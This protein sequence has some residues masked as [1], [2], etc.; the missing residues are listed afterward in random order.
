MPR[1]LPSRFGLRRARTERVGRGGQTVYVVLLIIA[2]VAVIVAVTFPAL[3]F[4]V[5]YQ[6]KPA[7]RETEPQSLLKPEDTAIPPDTEAMPVGG[8]S[9]A[10]P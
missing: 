5:T 2:L 3:E 9:S 1:A 7:P 8:G 4:F 6:G 10:G